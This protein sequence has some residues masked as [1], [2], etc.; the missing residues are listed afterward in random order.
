MA[1]NVK[2]DITKKNMRT[3]KDIGGERNFYTNYKFN[4]WKEESTGGE[5][6][7][8]PRR[9]TVKCKV[10]LVLLTH[11]IYLGYDK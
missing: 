3:Y 5:I 11:P 9:V 10:N 6:G 8:K 4:C 2:H 7:G 1:D